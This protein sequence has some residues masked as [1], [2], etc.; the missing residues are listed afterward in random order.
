MATSCGGWGS[1]FASGERR[2]QDPGF[3]PLLP[4]R[5]TSVPPPRTRVTDLL[6]THRAL[7]DRHR[8]RLVELMV[9]AVSQGLDPN[10]MGFIIGDTKGEFGAACRSE[11]AG[12]EFLVSGTDQPA[13]V[14]P[15]GLDGLWGIVV[16]IV[17]QA[18]LA[19]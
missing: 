13:M 1:E 9:I 7:L 17:P 5:S 18:L 15:L 12:D 19:L 14:V 6:P 11:G 2:R 10:E 16:A 8:A 4:G 3:I